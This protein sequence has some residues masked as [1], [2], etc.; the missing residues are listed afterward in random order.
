ML[1]ILNAMQRNVG[2][3]VFSSL[4]ISACGD[5]AKDAS[6]TTGDSGSS[7]SDQGSSSESKEDKTPGETPEIPK[8]EAASIYKPCPLDK[9]WGRFRVSLQAKFSAFEGSLANGVVPAH[10]P[11]VVKTQGDC[12]LYQPPSLSCDPP[13]GPNERC[14]RSGK[15][16]AAPRNQDLGKVYVR[17]MSKDLDIEPKEPGFH[18]VNEGT[19][20][21][22]VTKGSQE[23]QLFVSDAPGGALAL[24][25]YGIEALEGT[26]TKVKLEKGKDLD[27]VWTAAKDSERSKMLLSLNVNNHGAAASWI[28]CAVPD[29]GS[30]ALPGEL[31]MALFDAGVSGFPSLEFNRV[32]IDS[33]SL[34]GDADACLEFAVQSP[35]T[36]DVE[37]PGL[38]SCK[39]DSDCPEGQSCKDDLSC[40]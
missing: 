40:G 18:Y 37:V 34:S 32:S 28:T 25:A 6:D 2:A 12:I 38:V 36:I 17:G 13:C 35:V 27:L 30:Y 3:L 8:P 10:V 11:D 7:T 15:C 5:P 29:T 1:A 19:L 16:I 23:L 24:H 22:P 14:D 9:R 31:I 21:H 4:L 26:P 33:K 39:D 20:P